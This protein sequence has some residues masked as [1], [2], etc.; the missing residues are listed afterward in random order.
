[1]KFLKVP[2]PEPKIYF[3]FSVLLFNCLFVF[4]MFFLFSSFIVTPSGHSLMLPR[5]VASEPLSGEGLVITLLKDDS[6]YLRDRKINLLELK[7]ILASLSPILLKNESTL[8]FSKSGAH[9]SVLIKADKSASVGV[10]VGI[11][12]MLKEAGAAKIYIAT[13]E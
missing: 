5:G 13:N 6:V 9:F 2:H 8:S 12:D 3:L 4:L 10:L 1:M 7:K 11:W